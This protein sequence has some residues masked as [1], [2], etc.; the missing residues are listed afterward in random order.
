MKKIEKS[1][2]ALLALKVIARQTMYATIVFGLFV[3]AASYAQ[4]KQTADAFTGTAGV[5]FQLSLQAVVEEAGEDLR[6]ETVATVFDS[7]VNRVEHP[8]HPDTIEAVLK[9]F[10]WVTGSDGSPQRRYQYSFWGDDLHPTL[11][12]AQGDLAY[13]LLQERW[14]AY[15][16]G[17]YQPETNIRWFATPY[18]YRAWHAKNLD[19]IGFDGLHFQFAAPADPDNLVSC[20]RF[21]RPQARPEN[22]LTQS[23]EQE[24]CA[25]LTSPRPQARPTRPAP[26][27]EIGDLLASLDLD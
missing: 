7:L 6:P 23:E 5:G 18:A 22:L 19:C 2:K 15:Q 9:E 13:R 26:S 11:T 4:L 10:A 20:D 1:K 21:I 14:M 3:Y 25:P 24:G 27:D 16:A 12:G 17:T 8:D